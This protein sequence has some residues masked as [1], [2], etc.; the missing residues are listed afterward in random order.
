MPQNS[1]PNG[2][3]ET[4]WAGDVRDGQV[5][6]RRVEG[7]AETIV[8][9]R[10]LE[11]RLEDGDGDAFVG[12]IAE[13]RVQISGYAD[14]TPWEIAIVKAESSVDRSDAVFTLVLLK[15]AKKRATVFPAR[16]TTEESEAREHAAELAEDIRSGRVSIGQRPRRASSKAALQRLAEVAVRAGIE[17]G[18]SD[19]DETIEAEL[20]G[21]HPTDVE[22]AVEVARR[23]AALSRSAACE[24]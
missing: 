20:H 24:E 7:R 23:V 18:L 19:I 3:L 10:A 1:N 6:L 5:H 12:D 14:R 13:A 4:A 2:K 15:G 9:R 8:E 22:L 21:C 16:S 17:H 11:Q